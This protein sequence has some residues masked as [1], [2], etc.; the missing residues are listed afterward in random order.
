MAI[1]DYIV[2][3]RYICN[4]TTV[5]SS[6]DIKIVPRIAGKI[7]MIDRDVRNRTEV[8]LKEDIG[9]GIASENDCVALDEDV[10]LAT[11][12]RDAA[13]MGIRFVAPCIV[14]IVAYHH[15]RAGAQRNAVLCPGNVVTHERAASD[16]A[17]D[18]GRAVAVVTGTNDGAVLDCDIDAPD[19][20]RRRSRCM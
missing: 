3:N 16:I 1:N 4:W 7:V 2:G 12:E 14:D 18:G 15:G 8:V 9:R 17:T 10:G 20:D 19:V 6:L 13:D 11:L 5:Q